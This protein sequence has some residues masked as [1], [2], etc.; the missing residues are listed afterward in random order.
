[1]LI[2]TDFNEMFFFAVYIWITR[3]TWIWVFFRI[4]WSVT[5]RSTSPSLLFCSVYFPAI[6]HIWKTS[7]TR[8]RAL[9]KFRKTTFS[10]TWKD[11][12]KASTEWRCEQNRCLRF[13]RVYGVEFWRRHKIRSWEKYFLHG[14]VFWTQLEM[15]TTAEIVFRYLPACR[16]LSFHQD[17]FNSESVSK[18]LR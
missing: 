5:C 11:S 12:S 1:M 4:K 8:V 6:L 18:S 9:L 2:K 7:D 17:D 15:T 14:S 10:I 13:P 3:Q 16:R